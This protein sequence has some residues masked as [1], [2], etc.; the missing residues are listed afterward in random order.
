MGGNRSVPGASK[1][2]QR[3]GT[4]C[5]VKLEA[6]CHGNLR[7]LLGGCRNGEMVSERFHSREPDLAQVDH[8]SSKDGKAHAQEL[9]K[10]GF[11]SP[12]VPS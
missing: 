1:V 4:Y 12:Q 5:R 2:T 9:R 6:R 3:T 11:A 7:L 8:R 10:S